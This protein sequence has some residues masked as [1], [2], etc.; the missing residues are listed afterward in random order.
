MEAS[1]VE[2]ELSAWSQRFAARAR[3]ESGEIAAIL[4]LAARAD[5][6]SFAGGIPDPVTFPRGEL[7]AIL[8]EL[9][10]AGDITAFQ[11]GPTEGLASTR[12]WL[13][14]RLACLEGRAP[15]DGELMVTSGGIEALELLGKAFLEPGDTVV[16]EGPT[17]LGAIMSFRAFG[18]EVVA[19]SLDDAGLAVDELEASLRDGLRP[20]LIYSIP[21]HQNP[22][23]VTLT[24][25]RRAA[26]VDLARRYGF[27]VVEDVA[28]REL[29]WQ[30]ERP[31]TLWAS[32]ADV[33]VQIGTFSK[34]FMPGTRLGWACG[35]AEVV[36]KLVWGKQ[37]TD[38]CAGTLGQRLLEEY[39]RRGLLDEQIRRASELYGSRAHALLGALDERFANRAHWTRP[40]GG[41][42]SWLTLPGVDSVELAARAADAG[43][44]VVPGVPFYPDGR[45]RDALRLSFSRAHEDEIDE[46]IAR[47][48]EL[49]G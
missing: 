24:D 48:A 10:E 21:D 19:V 27:L 45:G 11:Y 39:G 4:A 22:A 35:P 43:V 15:G 47:L 42:F 12:A 1:V 26:L 25:E 3:A 28:Y 6:I 9:A 30:R 29:T 18:A 31:G 16:V 13:G 8:A 34:T 36:A 20:K 23:G 40:T 33:V 41:F 14:E 5:V 38:Q 46:G 49:V 44:A 2:R 17:Y 7:A 37:L 32:G